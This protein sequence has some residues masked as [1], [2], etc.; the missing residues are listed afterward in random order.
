MIGLGVVVSF[1]LNLS[2][3]PPPPAARHPHLDELRTSSFFSEK[4]PLPDL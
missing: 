3:D 4:P 1:E 2:Q